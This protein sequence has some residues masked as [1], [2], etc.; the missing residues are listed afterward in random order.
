MPGLDHVQWTHITGVMLLLLL[1]LLDAVGGMVLSSTST[2]SSNCTVA[3][4][5]LNTTQYEASGTGKRCKSR[6]IHNSHTCRCELTEAATTE[7][8][9]SEIDLVWKIQRHHL[10]SLCA[11]DASSKWRKLFC[12]VF[13]IHEKVEISTSRGE[14]MT[15]CQLGPCVN[16][17]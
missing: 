4:P 17:A 14:K 6:E 8:F 7:F 11:A 13:T 5:A 3:L 16:V 15:L 10:R 2:A 1:R 12:L 9:S